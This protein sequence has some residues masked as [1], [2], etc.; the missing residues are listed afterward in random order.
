MHSSKPI[1]FVFWEST[2]EL[3]KPALVFL[4]MMGLGGIIVIWSRS[5]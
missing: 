2:K 1:L 4:V 5:L 3:L